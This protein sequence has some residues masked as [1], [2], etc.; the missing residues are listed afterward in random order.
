MNNE[1]HVPTYAEYKGGCYV[2]CK[3]KRWYWNAGD[4]QAAVAC[5]EAHVFNEKMRGKQSDAS[6]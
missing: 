2:W 5:H 6:K 4:K 3:C 1:K